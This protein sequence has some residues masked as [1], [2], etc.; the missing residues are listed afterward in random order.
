MLEGSSTDEKIVEE[1]RLM[2]EGKKVIVCL[3]SDHS[4]DHVL[5]ELKL[6]APLVNVGS[7]CVVFDTIVEDMPEGSFPD[8][9][10]DKGNNPRTAVYE[11][12]KSN[13]NFEIDRDIENKF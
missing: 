2:A 3:D 9:P 5:R 11:F 10:R 8:R 6:Y 4:H 1:I 12:L 13:D 7:Y